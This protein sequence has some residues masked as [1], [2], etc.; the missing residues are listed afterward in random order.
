VNEPGWSGSADTDT[1]TL[2]LGDLDN[3]GKNDLIAGIDGAVDTVWTGNG[4][5]TFTQVN[6]P[7]WS[8][9]SATDTRAL[10]LGDLDSDGKNDLIVGLYG[11]ADTAWKGNGD[12]TF[13]QVTMPG[14]EA[15]NTSS[16]VIADFDR[17]GDL[18]MVCGYVSERDR[19]FRNTGGSAG[20][21]VT[22]TAPARLAGSESDAILRI[23]VTHNGIPGDNWLE[24]GKW[25]LIFEENDGDPLNT[26]EANAL[27]ENLH[28]YLDDGDDKWESDEDTLVK[29]IPT[30]SLS[31]GIQEII[32]GD[33]N[34]SLRVSAANSKTYFVVIELTDDAGSQTPDTF[35]VTFDPDADSLNL[36]GV[37]DSSVSVAD[38]SPITSGNVAIDV[39]EFDDPFALTAGGMMALFMIHRRRKYS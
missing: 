29:T 11:S 39:P 3:D 15:A 4:D 7:G 10:A 37:E 1:R 27:I 12:G 13:S 6:E 30:L 33:E 19:F 17:D 8:D 2:A 23:N 36:D 14:W 32:F 38:S 21:T 20:Y 35:Q 24:I 26:T 34:A 28:V 31:G 18:D 16:S 25:H 9:S 22:D 5:G